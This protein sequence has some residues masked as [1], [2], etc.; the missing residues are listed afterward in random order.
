MRIGLGTGSTARYALERI[1]ALLES[2]RLASVRGVPSSR[3]T[4]RIAR[5]L[6]IPLTPL[7]DNAVLDLNIDG[8]DEVDPQLNLI[9]GGGGAMLREK[10]LA[11]AARRNI[12]I[13][14]GGK[15]SPQLGTHRPV[16]VEVLPFAL[17]SV[18]RYLISLGASVTIRRTAAG[19]RMRTD[20]GNAVLDAAFGPLHDPEQLSERLSR[21]AGLIEHGLF[22]DLAHDLIVADADGIRHLA[23]SST[24]AG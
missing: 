22:I 10:V 6:K 8:A 1:S 11:Q 24:G 19:R 14:D 21:R 2:K 18:E 4:A 20:Q 23:R 16:P 9:K 7:D 13:V 15:L 12:F 5:A 17:K 3:E